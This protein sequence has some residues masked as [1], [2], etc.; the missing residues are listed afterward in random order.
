M[1]LANG[2]AHRSEQENS[3]FVICTNP[4]LDSSELITFENPLFFD[5]LFSG[6]QHIC[7]N[8][9]NSP[10]EKQASIS[11]D[12]L[13]DDIVT[14]TRNLL[15]ADFQSSDSLILNSLPTHLLREM[16]GDH[17]QQYLHQHYGY[18]IGIL[19][20]ENH[21]QLDRNSFD[22]AHTTVQPVATAVATP[23]T[24]A[25]TTKAAVKQPH[26]EHHQREHPQH[27]FT[28][29]NPFL[30]VYIEQRREWRFVQQKMAFTNVT[31]CC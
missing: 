6:Q 13:C 15:H 30:L 25:T 28:R 20:D 27:R 2:V 8:S 23:S 3:E 9:S 26:N 31:V 18:N 10:S 17:Y 29:R 11:N 12:S 7:D 21:H 16:Y 4:L 24:A 22:A 14:I 1:T 5:K 19:S